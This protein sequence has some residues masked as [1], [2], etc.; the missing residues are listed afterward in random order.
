MPALYTGASSKKHA[1]SACIL[2]SCRAERVKG[3]SRRQSKRMQTLP[4]SYT[5]A[6][7]KGLKEG[8]FDCCGRSSDWTLSLI[9][10]F[11]LSRRRKVWNLHY[12]DRNCL[13][14]SLYVFCTVGALCRLIRWHLH[15]AY[16]RI[17]RTSWSIPT[18][19]FLPGFFFFFFTLSLHLLLHQRI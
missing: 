3:R 4:V 7:L 16:W 2:H 9:S 17:N 14:L 1:E 6:R 11:S 10:A 13:R 15:L 12:I 5:A 8:L 19:W 18:S